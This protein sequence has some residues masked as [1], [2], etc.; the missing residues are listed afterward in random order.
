VEVIAAFS[1]SRLGAIKVGVV[2]DKTRTAAL[3]M[4]WRFS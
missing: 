3:P 4:L 2:A 1:S